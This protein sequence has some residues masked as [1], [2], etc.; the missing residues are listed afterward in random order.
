M[1]YF[2]GV[3]IGLLNGMFAAGA[4]QVLV[5]YLIF[6]KKIETHISRAV[7]MSLLSI[8]SLFAFF[9]Y[10]NKVQID[11]K[12]AF[13]FTIISFISGV[14]GSELMKRLS[15]NFLNLIS[16]LLICGLTIYKICI[17]G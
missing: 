14:I 6:V 2:F 11:I 15:S 12:V 10:V 17:G 8:S 9:S 5:I 3:L 1:I 4:G 13:Y 7:S 16:G